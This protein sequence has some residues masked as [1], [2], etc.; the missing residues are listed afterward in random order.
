MVKVCLTVTTLNGID[1]IERHNWIDVCLTLEIL[2][3]HVKLVNFT[4]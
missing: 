4:K 1:T 3:N 2:G